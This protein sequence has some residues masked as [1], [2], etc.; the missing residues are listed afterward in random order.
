MTPRVGSSCLRAARG[1]PYT[2]DL[3]LIIVVT[4][5]VALSIVGPQNVYTA[6]TTA[7]GSLTSLLE[8]DS[9]DST[10]LACATAGPGSS[11]WNRMNS[12]QCK[13]A[14]KVVLKAMLHHV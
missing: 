7:G 6:V 5:I 1:R 11:H 3:I 2:R 10:F 14:S 8:Y 12:T 9:A 4:G 13:G